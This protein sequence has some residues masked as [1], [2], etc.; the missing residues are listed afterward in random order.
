MVSLLP[1]PSISTLGGN[2]LLLCP[3]SMKFQGMQDRILYI[4]CGQLSY[5]TDFAKE[6]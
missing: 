3:A 1:S 2:A 5:E 4:S 6:S